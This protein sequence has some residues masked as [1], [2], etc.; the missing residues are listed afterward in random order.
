MIFGRL[1]SFSS[2]FG[3][4]SHNWLPYMPSGRAL[5]ISHGHNS[6]VF[7][8]QKLN[9]G[10]FERTCFLLSTEHSFTAYRPISNALGPIW[11]F[12]GRFSDEIWH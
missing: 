1:W 3:P 6:F 2:E 8:I 11:C 10:D 12:S 5:G 7:A 9:P 4:K